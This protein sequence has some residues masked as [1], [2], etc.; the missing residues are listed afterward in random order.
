MQFMQ[1]LKYMSKFFNFDLKIC[2]YLDMIEVS[3]IEFRLQK[4]FYYPGR[5]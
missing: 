1:V 4:G 2:S 3:L 5:L